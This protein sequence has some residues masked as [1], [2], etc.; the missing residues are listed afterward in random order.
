MNQHLDNNLNN[1]F[2]DKKAFKILSSIAILICIFIVIFNAWVGPSLAPLHR[3]YEEI[4]NINLKNNASSHLNS[5]QKF[6]QND[7]VSLGDA[8]QDELFEEGDM[9]EDDVLQDDSELDF[10]ENLDEDF[11]DEEEDIVVNINEADIDEL[12]MIP[13]IGEVLAKRIISYRENYGPF[14]SFEELLNIKGIGEKKLE[15]MIEY[16]DLG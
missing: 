6:S 1:N 11:E 3:E 5:S 7:V 8:D 13:Y 16:I 4:F 14:E 10:E 9:F 2:D 12:T 15:K